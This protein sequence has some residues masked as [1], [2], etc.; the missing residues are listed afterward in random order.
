MCGES[1]KSN[2]GNGTTGNGTSGYN[3][4]SKNKNLHK[5]HTMF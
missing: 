5:A 3:H 4:H 1:L 2:N